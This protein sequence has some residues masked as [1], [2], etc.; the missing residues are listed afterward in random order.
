MPGSLVAV[1]ARQC[2]KHGPA[3]AAKP[4]PR[5]GGAAASN[6]ITR[7]VG[8]EDVLQFEALEDMLRPGDAF[9]LCTDGLTKVVDD[10]E[11]AAALSTLS[12]AE[13]VRAL[14]KR[15]SWADPGLAGRT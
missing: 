15:V 5:R 3:P 11:I 13:T 9:L 12:P 4:N 7:A 6:G 1:S 10:R 2:G 14:I 8:T